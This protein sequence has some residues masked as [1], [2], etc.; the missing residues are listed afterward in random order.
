[1]K[2]RPCY[3]VLK[4]LVN[5]HERCLA[6]KTKQQQQQQQ[7]SKKMFGYSLNYFNFF[8]SLKFKIEKKMEF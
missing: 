3:T 1:M 5:F 7:K 2:I 4:L 6:T 8:I